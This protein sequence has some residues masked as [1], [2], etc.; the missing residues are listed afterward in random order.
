MYAYFDI[1]PIRKFWETPSTCKIG[2]L[3]YIGEVGSFFESRILTG[4][5]EEFLL[6]FRQCG[7][8]RFWRTLLSSLFLAKCNVKFNTQAKP[9]AFVSGILTTVCFSD[10]TVDFLLLESN[11]LREV[12]KVLFFRGGILTFSSNLSF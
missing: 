4:I 10:L 5:L 1:K 12:R 3:K 8:L 7:V 6:L 9:A 2:T 11:N